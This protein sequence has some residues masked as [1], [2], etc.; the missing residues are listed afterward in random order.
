[1]MSRGIAVVFLIVF[2]GNCYA[3]V[4]V[5]F[6][7]EVRGI[8]KTHCFHCHGEEENV[9]GGLDLRLVRWMLDGGDSGV[10]IVAGKPEKSLIYQRLVSHEMPPD[11]SKQISTD[12]LAKVEHWIRGG[13]KTARPEPESLGDDYLITDEER[14]HWAYQTIKRPEVPHVEHADSVANPIDAFLLA[15]LEK[16]GHQFNEPATA[17]HLV[18]R[19]SFDLLGLPPEIKWI[20]ELQTSQDPNHWNTLVDKLLASPHYGERWGRHWLDVAGYADS[21]GYSDVDAERPHAWRYRDYVIRAFNEGMPFDQFI[22]EQLAGDELITSPMNNLSP[23]D[24]EL[25]AATGFLRMAPDGTGGAVDDAQQARNDTI[26]D[27]I[28]IVS[29]SLMSVTLSCAQCHDHRYDPISQE[30]YYCFRAVFDPAFDWQ[31]WKN[32]RQRLISLY[33]DADRRAAAEVEK[34]AKLIDAA[35]LKKRNEFIASTFEEQL[36][37]LPDEIHELA[38]SAFTTDVKK[39]TPEQKEIFRKHPN[40]NVSASSL[41]LYNREAADELKKMQKDAADVRAKKP[42]QEYVRALTEAPGN[43]PTS[44]LFYRGDYAQPKQE[45]TPAG[46]TI[47]RQT[48][49]LAEIPLSSSGL[50]TSGRRLALADYLTDPKHP[51]TARAIMNRVWMHHFGIGLVTTPT[52]F[53]VLGDPPTHPRLLDWLAA[54]F[55]A[56]GWDLK[57]MHRLILTSNAWRQAVRDNAALKAADPD[58]RWY[59]GARL[60]R[61]DAEAIRDSLLMIS[62]E[63]NPKQFGPPVPVMPDVVGRIVIGK[64]NSSAGR[65]GEVI[66]MKGEE[67]RRSIYI[68]VRRSRPLS[69]METFDQPAMS[70]NCDQRRPSTSATQSLL[71]LNSVDLIER[72]RMTASLLIKAF[73]DDPAKRIELAWLKMYSRRIEE[74]EL[75]DA[76]AFVQSMTNDLKTQTAYQPKA[77]KPPGRSADEEALAILCQVLLSSNEFLYVQ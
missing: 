31:K 77:E 58:N 27:T 29:S 49:D 74:Q 45:L 4:E 41:Y 55:I 70:P 57:H 13:A 20:S 35:V 1:M 72:S 68:Q 61:L 6:E 50:P 52:D 44:R 66:D 69:M 42:K 21:E 73:P 11:A 64:E 46:L 3:Q 23:K 26:A 8:F 51:L 76:Q 37:K 19:L 32:P 59:G 39:R 5:H 10:A 67:L 54:E 75:S 38:R 62:G 47:V 15:K 17:D 24:V 63:L 18:R 14:A 36:A 43:V 7:S 12:E 34:E 71:M 53:G 28:H 40:L 16:H 56:S 9:E 65:P 60:R 22:R 30:D 2:S 48:S 25:L 33:T